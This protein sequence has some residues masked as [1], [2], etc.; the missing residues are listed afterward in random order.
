MLKFDKE[1]WILHSRVQIMRRP[2]LK[3]GIMSTISGIIVHQTGA[4]T[5]QSSLSSYL[6]IGANG[7]HFL[8]DKDGAVYQT[9]SIYWEQWHVGKLKSRCLY[10]H[11]CSPLEIKKLEKMTVSGM[12]THE[13][14]KSV[15]QRFPSNSDSIG[16]EL[17]GGTIGNGPDPV[18]ETVTKPQ[19]VSLAWL[20]LELRQTFD[21]PLTE[22][23]RHP[24]VSRKDPHEAE[25]A[26]W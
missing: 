2:N 21:L 17:V 7:A 13:M 25:T 8:I 24:Q 14:K 16:I 10:E 5:A 23:F 6:H 19:N 22:V 1:G 15:P 11:R 4:S 12:N 26:I 3:H 9:G 18:F 20:V